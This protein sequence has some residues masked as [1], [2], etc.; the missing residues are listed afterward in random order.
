MRKGQTQRKA[1]REGERES[2]ESRDERKK[3]RMQKSGEVP[4]E[5]S[6]SRSVDIPRLT[7]PFASAPLTHL[8][9]LSLLSRVVSVLWVKV[10]REMKLVLE[11][12]N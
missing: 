10:F 6:S 8:L 11:V 1:E 9:S 7:P 4:R 12:L 5:N 2:A 3:I